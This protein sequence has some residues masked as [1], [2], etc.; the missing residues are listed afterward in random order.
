MN[1]KFENLRYYINVRPVGRTRHLFLF[2]KWTVTMLIVSVGGLVRRMSYL[3]K[4]LIMHLS[5]GRGLQYIM[6][7]SLAVF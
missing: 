3:F 2:V 7:I 1:W 5:S 4:N 6:Q